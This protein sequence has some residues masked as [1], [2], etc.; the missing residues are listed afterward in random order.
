MVIT[1]GMGPSFIQVISSV[2]MHLLCAADVRVSAEATLLASVTMGDF[3]GSQLCQNGN[4]LRQ[5]VIGIGDDTRQCG[6][7]LESD[8][9]QDALRIPIQAT[10]DNVRDGDVTG[11]I[12]MTLSVECNSVAYVLISTQIKVYVIML[13]IFLVGGNFSRTVI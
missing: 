3:S 11:N 1:E 8:D 10:I 7:A 2:P 12:N 9:W 4:S 13:K 5:A 6:G